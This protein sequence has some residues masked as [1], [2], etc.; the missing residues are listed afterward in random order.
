MKIS[1]VL[2]TEKIDLANFEKLEMK[3]E[4]ENEEE[5]TFLRKLYG[6]FITGNTVS[7]VFQPKKP[8]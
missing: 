3:L 4:A 2:P 8:V 7:F 6:D 5:K 1:V